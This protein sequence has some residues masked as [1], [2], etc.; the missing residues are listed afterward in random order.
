M[1][2][3]RKADAP[4]SGIDDEAV[5]QFFPGWI[6]HRNQKQWD[7]NAVLKD[8]VLAVSQLAHAVSV[9]TVPTSNA[10]QEDDIPSLPAL[11]APP[12]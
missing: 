12:T 2:A 6:T 8:L 11:D 4:G 7:E 3:L 1:A 5:E 10:P 9:D